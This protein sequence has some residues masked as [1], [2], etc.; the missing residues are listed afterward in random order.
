MSLFDS[1]SAAVRARRSGVDAWRQAL[2]EQQADCWERVREHGDQ[3]REHLSDRATYVLADAIQWL[4]ELPANSIHAVVTDPPYG[5]FEYEEKNHAKLRAG[6]GGVWRIPPSFDG[7]KRKPLPRFTVLSQ[8]EV[9]ALYSFFGALAYGLTRALVPGGHIFIAS[10]PLLSTMTFHAFQRAGLEKRGEV[11]RLVQTL[12]GGDRPKGAEAEFPDVSMM[13]RSCWE[14]WGVFRK[15]FEGTAAENLRKWGTG[16]LRRISEDEPFKDVIACSPT[17]GAEKDIAPHP[18]LKPQRFMR[19]VVRAVLPLGLGIVYDP[20]AGSS[21]TLAAAQ[22]LGYTSIG[23]DRDVQYYAMAKKAFPAL[24]KL[25][26]SE[27]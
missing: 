13:A 15:P 27:R 23:T 22:A 26:M 20:F 11:I 6:R 7:A 5:L 4:A 25:P 12:R 2:L 14:P 10:N 19:Q 18:S 1:T 9:T 21:S 17:R 16:G 8:E 24:A 3:R